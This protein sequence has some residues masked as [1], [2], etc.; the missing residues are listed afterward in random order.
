MAVITTVKTNLPAILAGFQA[1]GQLALQAAGQVKDTGV[2][3]VG[4]AANLAGKAIACAGVAAKAS[5]SAAV[6]VNVSVMASASVS[7][8]CGGPSS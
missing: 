4:D 1:Q 3:L 6:S 2:A 5:A 7:G 8:S